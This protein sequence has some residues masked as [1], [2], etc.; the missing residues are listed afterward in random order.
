[1]YSKTCYDSPAKS[2]NILTETNSKH[3]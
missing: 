2:F 1:M 3:N